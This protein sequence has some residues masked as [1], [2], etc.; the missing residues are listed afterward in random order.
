MNQFKG[1]LPIASYAGPGCLFPLKLGI[2]ITIVLFSGIAIQ[3]KDTGIIIHRPFTGV[4]SKWIAAAFE[5]MR[6]APFE[7]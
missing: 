4:L 1:L 2:P 5:K 7:A 3:E 6:T